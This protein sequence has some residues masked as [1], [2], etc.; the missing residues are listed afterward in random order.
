[1]KGAGKAVLYLG[2]DPKHFKT[3][4]RLIHC[5]LVE[6][7]PRPMESLEVKKVFSD[8]LD[9]THILFTSKSAVHIFFQYFRAFD[10]RIDQLSGKYLIAIG[11]ETAYSLKAEG[12]IPTYITADET[13]DGVIRVLSLLNLADANVLLPKSSSAR[14]LIAHF[15]VEHAVRHQICILYDTYFR[16]PESLPT[17]EDFSEIVFTSPVAV[18]GFFSLYSDIPPDVELH[19]IGSATRESLRQKRREQKKVTIGGQT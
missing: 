18:E 16:R 17:L 9:Y 5:P 3:Q 7:V 2:I 11:Q 19:P 12:A 4:K 8:I 13:S 15:L 10:Y 6:I 14:P 1:M